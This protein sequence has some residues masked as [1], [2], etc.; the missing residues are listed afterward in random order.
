PG[1]LESD[2]EAEQSLNNLCGD[3][4]KGTL[5]LNPMKQAV[6]GFSYPFEL[7][8]DH[9]LDFF[10]NA[11]PILKEDK[12]LPKVAKLSTHTVPLSSREHF[13][14][15]RPVRSAEEPG[16]KDKEELDSKNSE[17]EGRSLITEGR[18]AR[19]F[20]D[21]N[22]GLFC[23]LYNT[24]SGGNSNDAE[25]RNDDGFEE[26]LN[27]I[28]GAGAMPLTPCPS[29]VEYVTPVFARNYQGVWRYVVQIPYEGYFTQTVEVTQCLANKCHY[30]AGACLASPRWV[31]LLVAE[32]YYPNAQ[33]P[34]TQ[35]RPDLSRSAVG[36]ESPPEGSAY[37]SFQQNQVRQGQFQSRQGSSEDSQ[38]CDG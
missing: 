37:L 22:W 23:M 25:D 24:V 5:P 10:S 26:R 14:V 36:G 33:F 11:L 17:V 30:L 21:N 16:P 3:L 13:R 35:K 2:V 29:A 12:T 1:I 6:M 7:I 34:A 27:S 9:T 8:K 19:S 4:N 32:V 20:C 31:S 18:S 28:G 15:R 38:Y